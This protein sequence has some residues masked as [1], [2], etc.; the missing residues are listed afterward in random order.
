MGSVV[1]SHLTR[2]DTHATDLDVQQCADLE[3]PTLDLVRALLAVTA[4]RHD[5]S[6]RCTHLVLSEFGTSF[7]DRVRRHRLQGAAAD[8]LEPRSARGG[9][10]QIASRWGFPDHADC[11]RAVT[12]HSGTSPR[13][14]RERA[15]EDLRGGPEAPA[16]PRRQRS[17]TGER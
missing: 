7:T 4:R 2:T 14:V 6:G 13:D 12:R 5:T 9:I 15:S 17:R 3:R 10:S 8:L 16:G 1:S 11:T